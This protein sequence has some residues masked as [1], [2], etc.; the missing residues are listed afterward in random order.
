MGPDWRR[1]SRRSGNTTSREFPGDEPVARLGGEEFGAILSDGG[2]TEL[3]A[4]C[5]RLRRSISDQPFIQ[6]IRL[7]ASGA[8][9]HAS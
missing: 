5:E 4:A 9:T 6:G 8:R 3:A 1:D 7:T 2:P